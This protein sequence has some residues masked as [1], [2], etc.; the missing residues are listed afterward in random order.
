MERRGNPEHV[1]TINK[2]IKKYGKGKYYMS[3]LKNNV[4]IMYIVHY[5]IITTELISITRIVLL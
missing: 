2:M 1:E 3:L 4:I 5:H